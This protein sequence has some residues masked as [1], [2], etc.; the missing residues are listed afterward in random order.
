MGWRWVWPGRG[1]LER[2]AELVS[3]GSG[4]DGISTGWWRGRMGREWREGR[5]RPVAAATL[6]GPNKV[7]TG[8]RQQLI[9][10]VHA[11]WYLSK[12][13]SDAQGFQLMRTAPA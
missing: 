4:G 1:S 7:Y 11:A 9:H 12:I 6:Q 8:D 13:C 2:A 10:M 5:L 3:V